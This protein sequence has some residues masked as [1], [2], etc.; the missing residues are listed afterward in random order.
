MINILSKSLCEYCFAETDTEPCPECGYSRS[1][2][3]QDRS[4]LPVGSVL[5]GRYMIGRVLGKGGFGITYLAYDMKLGY[6]VAIKEYYP[7]GA[8]VRNTENLTVSTQSDSAQESFKSGAEKFYSEARLIAELSGNP[9]I[10]NVSD[11]FYENETVYFTMGYLQGRTLKSYIAKYGK[12]S[13][14]QAVYI[15]G[16]VSNA[17]ISAHK[18]NVLH[19]DISPDNIMVYTDGTVKLLDF[20]AARQVVTEGSASLSV[21]LKQGYAPLEQYQKKGKQGPWTDIYSLGATL[22]YSLT[23]DL[24]EDP[25]SRLDDDEEFS[26]NPHN[27][28]PKLWEI[29]RK[30]TMLR[31]SE[32]YQD[33]YEFLD[34]LD[35]S[36][37]VPKALVKTD[38]RSRSFG[39]VSRRKIDID[40]PE[41]DSHAMEATAARKD[42]NVVPDMNATVALKE[43]TVVP[44]MN[45][46]VALNDTPAPDMNATVALKDEEISSDMNATVALKEDFSS[47]MNATVALKDEEIPDM[48]VTVALDNTASQRNSPP[49]GQSAAFTGEYRGRE[50]ELQKAIAIAEERDRKKK[51]VKTGVIGVIILAAII[52]LI[53]VIIYSAADYSYKKYDDGVEITKY[54]GKAIAVDIPS[55][56]GGKTVVRIEDRA[57]EG[58][59]IE[60]VIIPDTVTEIG[61]Y[62]FKECENLT[63]VTIPDSVTKIEGYAF[64]SCK[65]LTDI[66]IPGSVKTMGPD[67]FWRCERLES[68]TVS[69]GVTKISAEIFRDCTSL[70]SVSLPDSLTEIGGTAF[71]NCTGLKGITI[72]D[73]VKKIGGGAFNKC[74]NLKKVS[75]PENCTVEEDTFKD[76]NNVEITIRGKASEE[77]PK[78]QEKSEPAK[79]DRE[80]PSEPDR[81]EPSKPNETQPSREEPSE[82]KREGSSKS[83]ETQPSREEPSEQK[84]EGSSKSGETQPSREEPSEPK[85]EGS[86]KPQQP[87]QSAENMDYSKIFTYKESGNGIKITGYSGSDSVVVIPAKIDGKSVVE[88]AND[89]FKNCTNITSITIS[90]GVTRIGHSTFRGCTALT[91]IT[92][93]SSV[94]EIDMWAFAECEK[95]KSIDIPEGVTKIGVY[96]FWR[97]YGF[98]SITIPDSMSYLASC[99]FEDCTNLKTASVPADCNVPDNA[100]YH[101]G[102][103]KIEYRK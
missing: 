14:E 2:Y 74:T 23:L 61:G 1:T 102:N 45:A 37:I 3:E 17:L 8:A 82:P 60:S 97:C 101:C 43:D 42:D 41:A 56:L 63:D 75:L 50:S 54:K 64:E 46:T 77:T 34:A 36:G 89:A 5:E 83:G 40:K 52:V 58:T 20:G 65:K 51:F 44:D 62:A 68:V 80:E 15:A 95:L 96:A 7:M 22:Y 28:S 71:K 72:P 48:N 21:I 6:K 13:E 86:S 24:L 67:I 27:I 87:S 92:I 33:I 73:G 70:K 25:M 11:V 47:D 12:I 9:N 78:Q 69:E 19:R 99:T 66:T 32:R 91:S 10:V 98:E 29:I 53:N 81:E 93:P 76:C 79:P 49:S 18:L 103:V 38:N 4:V 84:R 16:E 59:D 31:T 30:A 100:F 39:S 88:I 94:T 26:S 35:D 55:E 90:D 57:F 85:R